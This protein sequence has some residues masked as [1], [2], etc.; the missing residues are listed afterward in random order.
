VNVATVRGDVLLREPIP[1]VDGPI[2]DA[3]YAEDPAGAWN[4]FLERPTRPQREILATAVESLE[5]RFWVIE[6]R[7]QVGIVRLSTKDRPA[8]HSAVLYY[9]AMAHRGQRY[10][11]H[12]MEM[13]IR[14]AFDE[15]GFETLHADVL[16]VNE[17]SARLLKRLGFERTGDRQL[18]RT[19]RGPQQLEEWRL[20]RR[21]FPTK[22]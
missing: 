12:A 15:L 3:W 5:H 22:S 2:L 16:L 20:A 8:G 13:V 6:A 17:P 14:H 4:V 11:T 9:V 19:D 18:A 10:A 21:V 7:T 1:V